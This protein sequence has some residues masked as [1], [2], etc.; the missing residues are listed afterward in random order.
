[1]KRLDVLLRLAV[2]G[3]FV[4]HGAYGAVLAKPAWLDYLSVLGLPRTTWLMAAVGGAEIALG[5][6]ALFGP[7]PAE[8]LVVLAAW[9]AF[10]E[11]LRVPAGELG[12]EVVERASNIL[13][14][15]V[16]LFVLRLRL[17]LGEV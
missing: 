17:R 15:L 13:A 9:K 1:M 5:L 11:L 4:G 2:A 7:L 3:A 14:P 6:A 10:S 12:W 8:L 16:L